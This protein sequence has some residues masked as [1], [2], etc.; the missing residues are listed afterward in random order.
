MKTLFTVVVALAL[1]S[2][3]TGTSAAAVHE[4]TPCC[5]EVL[6]REGTLGC[7]P[8]GPTRGTVL[9]ADGK[10]PRLKARL[11]GVIWKGKTFHDDGTF[12]NRW[13]GG[14]Q[15]VSAAICVEPSWLDG[16]PCLVMQYAPDARVFGNVR[17][18]LRQIG[19]N[20][21]LGRSYDAPTRQ[22]KNWFVLRG[23]VKSVAPPPLEKSRGPR[24][25]CRPPSGLHE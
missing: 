7:G 8:L 12:I 15:A 21:W 14:V 1:A 20:M 10:H 4:A 11:Q 5:W 25:S 6:F 3:F 22:P 23:R 13:L 9:Y 16:Q 24:L 18:E 17:D 2:S 19:P